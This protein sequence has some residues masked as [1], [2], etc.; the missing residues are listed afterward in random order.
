M[1]CFT[2][3]STKIGVKS[4]ISL[5]QLFRKKW[6][7]WA[8]I[9]CGFA[10][11]FVTASFQAGNTIG[12][13]IAFA[14]S[15]QT[16][17]WPWIVLVSFSAIGLLFFKSFYKILER[18]MIL[19][20][21]VMLVSFL[22]TLFLSNPDWGM[23]LEGLSPKVPE[24]ALLLLVALVASSFSIGGAFYQSYLVQ[25]K[26]WKSNE[27]KPAMVEGVSGIL[28]L[29]VITGTIMMSA[30]AILRPQGVEV[31][32]AGDMG[33]ALAPLYGNWAGVV[34]MIGLFG[35]SFSSLVGNATIGG[36]LC[37]DALN[38]GRSLNGLPVKL[39][40]SLVIFIGAFVALAF[41]RL[42][43]ELI[44][45]AQGITIFAVPF[46]GLGI[47]LVAND[48]AIMG[49]SIN[50]RLLN[51]MGILGI[52]VLFFLAGTNFYQLFIK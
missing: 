15:L 6:G 45:F 29:G 40:I 49:E 30:A 28:V 33:I 12:A 19:M 46:I 22:F 2:L 36:T 16:P 24:G 39:F 23:V 52:L 20:V 26:G 13:G 1:I 44:V 25:E 32:S 43:L 50:G 17:A 34:F 3:M 48:K 21:S 47:L 10:L 31:T 18:V 35:A 27:S 41:G 8:A 42:P 7:K 9:A 14:E 38:Y 51:I 37:S 4:P 5:L 11:F